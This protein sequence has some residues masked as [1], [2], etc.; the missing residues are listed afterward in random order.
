M[1]PAL[2]TLRSRAFSFLLDLDAEIALTLGL[3]SGSGPSG[4]SDVMGLVAM[5]DAATMFFFPTASGASGVQD[6]AAVLFRRNAEHRP[7]PPQITFVPNPGSGAVLAA[8]FI[9]LTAQILRM[10]PRPLGADT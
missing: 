4:F 10:T 6:A 3:L 2:T 7:S 5:D 8:G 1:S 9:G